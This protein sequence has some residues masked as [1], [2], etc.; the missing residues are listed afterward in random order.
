MDNKK[1]LQKIEDEIMQLTQ[2]RKELFNEWAFLIKKNERL[3]EL[4]NSYDPKIT[5]RADELLLKQKKISKK[6]MKLLE[7][8]DNLIID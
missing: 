7:Q 1:K 6:V 3:Y 8:A 5:Q 4:D 2:T